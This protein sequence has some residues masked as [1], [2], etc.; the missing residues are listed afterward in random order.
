MKNLF[1][2]LFILLFSCRQETE[3]NDNPFNLPYYQFTEEDKSRLLKNY[4]NGKKLI[5]KSD[6]NLAREFEIINYYQGKIPY[7]TGTFSGGN[8]IWFYHDIQKFEY[9]TEGFAYKEQYLQRFETKEK[10]SKFY[11]V[12][13]F[14]L[15]NDST[16]LIID[17][18]QPMNT[19]SINGKTFNKVRIF[20]SNKNDIIS[21]GLSK[22]NVNKVYYDEDFG[23]V[24]YEEVHGRI[25]IL[26][27]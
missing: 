11:G 12:S 21:D 6:D 14:P 3:V 17:F 26:Q 8:M 2:L 16:S 18:S 10:T 15:W 9:K 4:F 5:F 13:S 27:N 25:W 1:L 22:R 24:K 23:I 19:I 20:N 7:G